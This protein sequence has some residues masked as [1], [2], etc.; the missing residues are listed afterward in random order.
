MYVNIQVNQD[1]IFRKIY[2]LPLVQGRAK[3]RVSEAKL[4][5]SM[6]PQR[7]VASDKVKCSHCNAEQVST[8]V[9]CCQCQVLLPTHT[10]ADDSEEARKAFAAKESETKKLAKAKRASRRNSI[11]ALKAAQ[12]LEQERMHV[13]RSSI[14]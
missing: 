8:N 7:E 12:G 13:R 10:Q 9:R 1:A 3:L 4:M 6:S 2:A 11:S 14:S 5:Q